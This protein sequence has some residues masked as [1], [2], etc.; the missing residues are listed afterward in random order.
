MEKDYV[1][2][3]IEE[4]IANY[5]KENPDYS[6][7]SY[8]EL[9]DFLQ[10]NDQQIISYFYSLLGDF[11]QTFNHSGN[12]IN[13]PMLLSILSRRFWLPRPPLPALPSVGDL[14]AGA[15]VSNEVTVPGA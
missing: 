1:E 15:P 2:D 8:N 11:F 4:E 13:S 6:E 12:R 5:L 7:E 14:Q 10:L 3:V 9:K